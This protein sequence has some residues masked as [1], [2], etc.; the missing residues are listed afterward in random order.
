MKLIR[1]GEAGLE[2][3]GILDNGTRLD[4]SAFGE[5]YDRSFFS[6][7][8]VTRLAH[9]FESNRSKCPI[10]DEHVR[11][12]PPIGLPS[13]F[14][15]VGLNYAAHARE[16]GLE[17]PTSPVLFS[18]A[19]S[20]IC[21]PYDDVVIPKGSEKSDWEVE[22]AFVIGKKASYVSETEAMNYV[23]GYLVHNDVSERAFQ[24][25]HGG[26]WVKGKGADT[27]APLGPW[28]VTKDEISDPNNLDLWLKLNG[29]TLQNSTTS[30]FIFDIAYVISYISQYMSLWPGDVISTGTP[31]GVGLGL[32][33]PRYLKPGD[34]MELS[35]E[36]LGISRQR[37]V[38]YN[39]K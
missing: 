39:D 11:L 20:A 1:C 17:P 2:K 7:D 16:S 18:K 10:I 31:A 27:F 14:I 28:L 25:E 15:C 32:K 38:A 19:T 8:G 22:L 21:G 36:G 4:V 3:P 5:D 35:V 33:P 26:Q 6:N 34:V 23:A 29:E 13:K 37:A 24:L 9:W 12:G 30:D